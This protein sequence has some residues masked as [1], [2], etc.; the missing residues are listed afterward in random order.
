V[1]KSLLQVESLGRGFCSLPAS[2]PRERAS[3]LLHVSSQLARRASVRTA[4][5]SQ[6]IPFMMHDEA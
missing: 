3:L 2:I 5:K 4:L 1:Q 6:P